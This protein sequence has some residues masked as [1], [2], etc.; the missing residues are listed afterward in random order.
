[1][2]FKIHCVEVEFPFDGR[3]KAT[4]YTDD[5][6]ICEYLANIES[7]RIIEVITIQRVKKALSKD[8]FIKSDGSEIQQVLNQIFEELEL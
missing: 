1:M 4:F 5:K 2:K 3:R 8:R 6:E 7:N